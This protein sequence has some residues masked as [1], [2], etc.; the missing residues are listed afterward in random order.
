MKVLSWNLLLRNM[1]WQGGGV[2]IYSYTYGAT[3]TFTNTQIHSNQAT[4]VRLARDLNRS[5][6]V[7]PSPLEGSFLEPS[8]ECCRREEVFMSTKLL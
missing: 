7:L 4:G 5:R 3:V 2:Y 6:N 8:V 1:L